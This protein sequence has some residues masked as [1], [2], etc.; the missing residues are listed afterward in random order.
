MSKF[1]KRKLAARRLT[2]LL[3]H[4]PED[5][6]MDIC[7]YVKQVDI[8]KKL[9]ITSEKLTEIVLEDKKGR[10]ELKND[11]IR[12]SQGHS[13]KVDLELKEVTPPAILY[14]G[15]NTNAHSS[16]IKEG[17]KKMSRI[18]VHL[19]S[20]YDKAVEASARWKDAIVVLK[21]DTTN[22]TQKFYLSSN[23]YYLTDDI[24][25]KHILDTNN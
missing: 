8:L 15:T 20:N 11:S 12:A 7:G 3:R 24:D 6:K 10:F 5:L 13:I 18:H 1:I 22:M 19:H 25:P 9:N 17:I 4:D 2:Y 21:I 14:H 23:G 16:I